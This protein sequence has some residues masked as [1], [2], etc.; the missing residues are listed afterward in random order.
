MPSWRSPKL[1]RAR[2]APALS[3]L[4]AVFVAAGCGGSGTPSAEEQ[5]ANSV[6]TEVAGWQSQIEGLASQ[7][8]DELSSPQP[9]VIANL[10]AEAQKAV[11][12]TKQLATNF[13]NL[14]P[15]PGTNGQTA[16]ELLNAFASDAKQTIDALKTDLDRLTA[17]SS[18]G[19]AITTVSG[20]AANV[21]AVVAKGKSTLESVQ[22]TASN[23]KQGF[24]DA[25]A[26]QD[27]QKSS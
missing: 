9:G 26:C 15:A 1:R 12:A 22:E 14:Q 24:Q 20:A 10:K 18:V 6:C 7:A 13:Q 23:L 21:S 25:E 8:K 2:V 5:W 19:E 17:S 11:T 16:K 4:A 3:I 27:L